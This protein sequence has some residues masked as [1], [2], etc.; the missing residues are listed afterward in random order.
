MHPFYFG[1]S[2]HPLYGVIH[3]PS[4]EV[5]RDASVLLCSSIGYENMRCHREFKRLAKLLSAAGYHVL[6][7]DYSGIGDSSGRFEEKNMSDWQQDIRLAKEELSAISGL[8][9]IDCI[10]ARLGATLACGALHD[11]GI[12]KMI[13]WDPVIDGRVYLQSLDK[14]QDE[15]MASPMWF[16]TPRKRS[17][18]P[19]NEFLG[20]RYSAE[21]LD[22]LDHEKIIDV[23]SLMVTRLLHLYT[24]DSVL[25]QQLTADIKD[26]DCISEYLADSS[27]WDELA[28]VEST[29]AANLMVNKIVQE[30][31]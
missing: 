20:Y 9:Q 23:S 24:K 8:P 21:L 12:R 31:A 6:R 5:Y 13:L 29:L 30:L 14:L 28:S 27:H 26:I 15:I 22:Q 18:I 19:D 1:D 7:F 2:E 11:Q 3:Y 10:G 4:G 16:R 25:N 17:E